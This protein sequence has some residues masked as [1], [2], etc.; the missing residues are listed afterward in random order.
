M[1]KNLCSTQLKTHSYNNNNNNNNSQIEVQLANLIRPAA[2]SFSQWVELW[3]LNEWEWKHR[4]ES[5]A[6]KIN[7][8]L[9]KLLTERF[10]FESV[11]FVSKHWMNMIHSHLVCC[12]QIIQSL[13]QQISHF[14][15]LMNCPIY[16][17]SQKQLYCGL[18]LLMGIRSDVNNSVLRLCSKFPV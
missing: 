3:F 17:K 9:I 14:R 18:D 12:N 1:L 4:K 13:I 5:Y 15:N 6:S 16:K 10:I 11:W 7:L 8:M 2:T